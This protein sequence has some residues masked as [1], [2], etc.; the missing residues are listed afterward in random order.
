[1]RW[2]AVALT[3][4][5]L[6]SCASES[7]TTPAASVATV[8][9]ST[10][11]TATS[12]APSST[13]ADTDAPDTTGVSPASSTTVVSEPT[14]RYEPA[15]RDRATASVAGA[16]ADDPALDT[17]AVVGERPAIEIGLP[18][19]VSD[20][21]TA[22]GAP[23][24]S[25]MRIPGGLLV[26]VTS[27]SFP[28]G[29]LAA[30]ELDGVVRWVRCVDDYFPVPVIAPSTTSPD[31]ALSGTSS[32]DTAA[33]EWRQT[34]Q[35][36]SLADGSTVAT[37][38]DL[39]ADTGLSGAAA[40]NRRLVLAEHGVAVFAPDD[41]HVLDAE[42][43]GLLRVDLTTWTL[44]T[45]TVPPEFDGHPAG[46]LQLALGTDGSLLRMGQVVPSG[47]RV[48]QSVEADGTWSTDESLR[49]SVWGPTVDVTWGSATPQIA[50]WDASGALLWSSDAGLP[51]RE[52]FVTARSGDVQVT[53]ACGEFDGTSPCPDERLVG[54]DVDTGRELWSLPGWRIVG[55]VADGIAYVTD[56][57]DV[58]S[59][60]Q[61]TGWY[62]LDTTTG[63]VAEAP[64]WPGVDT[65]RTGC[66]GEGDT[67]HVG[68][69][70]GIVVAVS[71]QVMRVWFP[72]ALT[73]LDTT[74]VDLV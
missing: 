1:V 47:L 66:C 54:L 32:F 58:A 8:G 64:Q 27:P 10:A 44:S 12:P 17:L 25:A 41:G 31:R 43:D 55:P 13:T 21:D 30:V 61:P 36:L 42:V 57:A 46:E 7:D 45:T 16:V 72:A 73:P 4:V 51:M 34:W 40:S 24:A 3:A 59:G 33:Q 62:V 15:C 74:R 56:S 26:T 52:G 48:P 37:L 69:L 22:A 29:M 49:G 39:V 9:S 35:V 2:I 60:A 53:V 20:G 38:D 68:A 5:A 23:I 28:G 50:A 19:A 11:E 65:F 67:Q 63:R 6:A 70:G 71:G 14:G 18:L